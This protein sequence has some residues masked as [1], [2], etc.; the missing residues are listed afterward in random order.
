MKEKERNIIENAKEYV[1][2][3]FENDYSGHDHWHSLRVY[4]M[5]VRLAEQ[6]GADIFIVELAALLHDVDDLK[7]SSDTNSDLKN[8]RS[9]MEAEHIEE[10]IQKRICDIIREVSFKGEESKAPSTKEGCCVQDAD[11]LDAMGA[12]GIARIFT[13]GGNN[14]RIMYNPEIQPQRIK[15]AY[16]YVNKG[17]TSVNH[18]Y[19]K[20]FHLKEYMNTD[21]A[22]LMAEEKELYMREY[23]SRFYAEWNGR[24]LLLS[25]K[26]IKKIV[27][28]GGPCAG[29]STGLKRISEEFYKLGY[30]VIIVPETATELITGGLTPVSCT[31]NEAF[32]RIQMKLQMEKEKIFLEGAFSM[33]AQKILIVYD[34]GLMDN[35]AYM[36]KKEIKDVLQYIGESE[37]TMRNRYDAVFHLETLAKASDELYNKNRA[38]N[39]ART[40]DA[41]EAIELDDKVI[42][43]WSGHKYFRSIANAEKADFNQKMK[44]LI[45]EISVFLN[46]ERYDTKRKYLVDYDTINA[47]E[48]SEIGRKI[49]I[50]QTYLKVE[51][52]ENVKLRQ[53]GEKKY[54]SYS[55][56]CKKEYEK[57]KWI[58]T[59]REV[60]EREYY[61]KLG[62]HKDSTPIEKDRYY[63]LYGGHY[64]TVDVFD[65]P[66]NSFWTSHVLVEVDIKD[67]EEICDEDFPEMLRNGREDVTDKEEYRNYNIY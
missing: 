41:K 37:E 2:K 66:Q 6:E 17:S 33:D 21:S 30:E 28:T 7:L 23:L 64:F 24:D 51:D 18:F 14:N 11:R 4:N 67:G 10:K 45:D 12:I 50:C 55:E 31:S 34:R 20:I 26:T 40:A 25:P 29:K 13:Y 44:N 15:N 22:K 8:A 65:L 63:I 47:N 53:R 27:I 49:R 39:E 16:D 54:A 43:A 3:H 38:S 9:F 35:L 32:Q 42:K 5:A 58:R 56:I 57:G 36:N 62:D 46:E 1:E 59:E 52:D 19:E 60:S 48:L 61:E